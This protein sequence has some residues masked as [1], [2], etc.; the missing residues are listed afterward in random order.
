MTAPGL[1]THR[2]FASRYRHARIAREGVRF[3]TQAVN[4]AIICGQELRACRWRAVAQSKSSRS[5]RS[6]VWRPELA[7]TP[8]EINSIN[9]QSHL[10]DLSCA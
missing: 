1:S 8:P 3:F 7:C 10:T 4:N 5:I 2:R 9:D 6:I